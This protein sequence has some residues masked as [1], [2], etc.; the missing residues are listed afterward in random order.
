LLHTLVRTHL[1]ITVGFFSPPLDSSNYSRPF[2]GCVRILLHH[3]P[4]ASTPRATPLPTYPL[5]VSLISPPLLGSG[6]SRSSPWSWLPASAPPAAGLS[7]SRRQPLVV[8]LLGT[9]FAFQTAAR[10]GRR[11]AA[12]HQ[13][14]APR[15]LHQ[16]DGRPGQGHGAEANTGPGTGTKTYGRDLI[17][18]AGK[19]DPVLIG[20]PGVG[21]AAVVEGLTQ[22]VVCGDAPS[23]LLDVA[24]RGWH[25]ASPAARRRCLWS[26]ASTMQCWRRARRGTALLYDHME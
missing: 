26:R 2:N 9:F 13:P 18:M 17:E 14:P 4:S 1:C 19:L 12:L 8:I 23:N 6:S 15:A 5:P 21:K 25:R 3:F 10:R 16:P 20:E 24:V 7:S 22:L 11:P